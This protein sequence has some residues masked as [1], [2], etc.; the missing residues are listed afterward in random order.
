M[1]KK[2]RPGTRVQHD[3]KDSWLRAL[4]GPRLFPLYPPHC[5]EGKTEIL[6]FPVRRENS[7]LQGSG[8]NPVHFPSARGEIHHRVGSGGGCIQAHEL[9]RA[10]RHY[11]SHEISCQAMPDLTRVGD[12]RGDYSDPVNNSICLLLADHPSLSDTSCDLS[13]TT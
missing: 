11:G 13:K 9:R 4:C 6:A 2:S 10:A 12:R 3:E 5:A 7:S 1:A 8:A